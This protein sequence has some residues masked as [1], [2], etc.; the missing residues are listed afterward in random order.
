MNYEKI[1][2]GVFKQYVELI[3]SMSTDLLMNK[4]DPKTYIQNLKLIIDKFDK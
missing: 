3:I 4:I 1:D 2:G